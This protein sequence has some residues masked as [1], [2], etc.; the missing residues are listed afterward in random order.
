MAKNGEDRPSLHHQRILGHALAN[1][2]LKSRNDK[3]YDPDFDKIIR[4]L[5]PHWFKK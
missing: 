5:A 3:I 2:T 1:Y 4:E